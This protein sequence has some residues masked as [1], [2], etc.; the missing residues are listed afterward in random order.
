MTCSCGSKQAFEKC[1]APYLDGTRRPPTA[2]ALMRS[3]YVA[4]TLGDVDYLV[5][6]LAPESR[7]DESAASAKT[8]ADAVAFKRL[9]I[10]SADQG[11]SADSTGTVEFMATFSEKGSKWDHH[12]VSRFRKDDDGMWL[13]IEGD[14]H[15]H[16]AGEGHDHGHHPEHLTEHR[17]GFKPV[18]PRNAG[19]KVG[20]N[21][22]CPCGSGRKSKKCCAGS[23]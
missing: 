16:R 22:P 1:C 14:S 19:S 9:T 12:E 6:T 7:R 23:G 17:Q 18:M 13:F 3:R 2:E 8:W 15:R 5:R 11:G 10:L 21:D 20:R 4:Y